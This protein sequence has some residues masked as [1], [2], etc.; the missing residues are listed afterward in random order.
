MFGLQFATDLI[1]QGFVNPKHDNPVP[2]APQGSPSQA[3]PVVLQD[4]AQASRGYGQLNAPVA[5]GN[6]GQMQLGFPAQPPA[7]DSVRQGPD[8]AQEEIRRLQTELKNKEEEL[9]KAK[10]EAGVAVLA[11]RMMAYAH[12]YNVGR[13]ARLG[14]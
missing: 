9:K 3:T 11:A 5:Y 12:A 7:R 6:P 14:T 13:N 2:Q 8:E 10:S 1:Q 4:P